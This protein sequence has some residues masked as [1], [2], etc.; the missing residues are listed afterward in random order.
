MS[1]KNDNKAKIGISIDPQLLGRIDAVCEA[2]GEPRSAFI[3]RVLV[4]EIAGEEEFVQDMENPFTRAVARAMT[5]S[6]KVTELLA[7]FVV[8]DLPAEDRKKIHGWLTDQ[9]ERGSGRMAAKKGRRITQGGL[10][11][12]V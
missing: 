8:S 3:E 12:N 2:R 5:A 11:S 7:K 9:L 10:A 4:N 6:P 1:N